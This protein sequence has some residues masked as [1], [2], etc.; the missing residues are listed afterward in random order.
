MLP[1]SPFSICNGPWHPLY[2]TYVLDSPHVQPLSRSSLV[3]PL[4]LNPQLQATYISSP[5]HRHLFAT[6]D[7]T[8]AA[9][10][11]AIPMLCHLVP[12]GSALFLEI[13]KFPF[14]HRVE[15][16]GGS[17]HAKTISI[18]SAISIELRLVTDR[19]TDTG[20]C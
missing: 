20:P 13:P 18:R 5:S 4:V 8:S 3:F 12:E 1:L 9:C 15:R 19:Q 11:A 14:L 7:R 6:H 17:S 16:V 2:S 10:S